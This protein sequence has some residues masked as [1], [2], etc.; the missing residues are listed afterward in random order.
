M[1][2]WI[3]Q[4]GV[5]VMMIETYSYGIYTV[6]HNMRRITIFHE[7]NLWPIA[8]NPCNRDALISV[9]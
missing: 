5:W 9:P 2:T 8:I 4:E 6:K 3:R 1:T 7:L